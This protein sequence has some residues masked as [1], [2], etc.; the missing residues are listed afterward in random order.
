MAL[1]TT[2]KLDAA[3]T[4]LHNLMVG[5]ATVSVRFENRSVQYTQQNVAELKTYIRSLESA[6]AIETSGV[7]T[8]RPFRVAW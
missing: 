3:R 8:R 5:S 1:T 2:Q 6:L 7:S 4:A